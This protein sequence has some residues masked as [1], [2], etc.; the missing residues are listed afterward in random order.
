[1]SLLSPALL[2]RQAAPFSPSKSP[3]RFA[4]QAPSP[5][6][7]GLSESAFSSNFPLLEHINL[8][9]DCIRAARTLPVYERTFSPQVMGLPGKL[10]GVQWSLTI[11]P[12][13]GH[14]FY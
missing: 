6:G 13:F 10:H 5:N 8:G 9:Y 2:P 7:L 3:R 4:T 12:V 11:V 14:D 1:M